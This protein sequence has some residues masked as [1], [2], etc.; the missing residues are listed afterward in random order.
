MDRGAWQAMVHGVG[1]D[2]ATKPP[3]GVNLRKA[4][5]VLGNNDYRVISGWMY[6]SWPNAAFQ[7]GLELVGEAL[8][9]SLFQSDIKSR[10]LISRVILYQK[11]MAAPGW[12]DSLAIHVG[13]NLT[14]PIWVGWGHSCL[15][16]VLHGFQKLVLAVH[17]LELEWNLLSTKLKHPKHAF[18]GFS[19]SESRL[20][21][22]KATFLDLGRRQVHVWG[23]WGWSLLSGNSGKAQ[24]PI[25]RTFM[26]IAISLLCPSRILGTYW[27]G[28]SSFS[29]ISFCLSYCSWDSQGKKYWS[30]L[31]FPSP[32]GRVLFKESD[33]T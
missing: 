4:V 9:L 16:F 5:K 2:L 7:M 8:T 18:Q 30:G 3:P 15:C 22:T 32:V 26:Y 12:A 21:V 1:Q 14:C 6:F 10:A 31:P 20:C 24:I 19:C 13:T 23:P 11:Q 28:G 29:D 33:I 17:L 27:S 25:I